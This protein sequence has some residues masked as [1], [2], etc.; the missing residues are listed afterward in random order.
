MYVNFVNQSFERMT[1]SLIQQC[2]LVFICT[3]R[4]LVFF[5]FFGE[6]HAP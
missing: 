3:E 4:P 2:P 6:K 5:F 1:E